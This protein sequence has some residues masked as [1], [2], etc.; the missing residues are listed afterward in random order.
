MVSVKVFCFN[1]FSENTFLI[2]S[3]SR[4]I[5]V[6]PGCYVQDEY[7]E[8]KTYISGEKLIPQSIINTHCH[9][10]HILGVDH[11]KE[12]YKIPFYISRKEQPVLQSAT[13]IAPVYG[14]S[15]FREP[16]PDGFIE[17]SEMITLGA[18]RWKVLNVPGHSP[19]H[20]ALY[21]ENE[22]LCL[23]GDVLF[24]RSIGRTDLPGGD[25]DTLINSIRDQ[26]FV[27][28]DDVVVFPGHGP[29]TTIGDE[30]HY[31][32]FCGLNT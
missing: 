30:K 22:K 14:F 9:I 12:F 16:E 24:L 27:L 21:E 20:I 1:A 5:I 8:L 31:N 3:D 13:L 26:L 32:P 11:L 23:A 29:E 19:G 18:S 2:K 4:C 28:P 10:D 7:D 6:D 17:E 15:R 25:Y